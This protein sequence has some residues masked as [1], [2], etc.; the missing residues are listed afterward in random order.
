MLAKYLLKEEGWNEAERLIAA[1]PYTVELAVVE[2]ASA[3]WRRVTLLGDITPATAEALIDCLLEVSDKVLRVE[4]QGQYL[5]AAFSIAVERGLTVYDAIYV[6]QALERR[7]ALATADAGQA[8]A[9]MELGVEAILV[10]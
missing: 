5:K 10:R 8:R 9:A 7:A 2:V 3:I 4:G 1:R 6:A